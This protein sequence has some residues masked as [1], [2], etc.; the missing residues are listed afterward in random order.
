[1]PGQPGNKSF[2]ASS[3]SKKEDYS[4]SEEK[5]AKRLLLLVRRFDVIGANTE[6]RRS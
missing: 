3:F 2:F 1:M 5:E 4:L 6:K